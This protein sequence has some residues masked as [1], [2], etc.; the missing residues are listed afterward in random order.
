MQ[1]K[2]VKELQEK[3][4]LPSVLW[5]CWKRISLVK[6][7]AP[8]TPNV[9]LWETFSGH[10]PNLESPLE[11]QKPNEWVSSVWRPH[12]HIIPGR[13]KKHGHFVL[14]LVTLEILTRSASNLAQIKVISFLT[15]NRNLFESTLEKWCG[16]I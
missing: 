8:A 10:L 7:F 12:Q 14:R 15:L 16:A 6:N 11:K 1:I 5:H 3:L 9:L 4:K 2:I 13:P